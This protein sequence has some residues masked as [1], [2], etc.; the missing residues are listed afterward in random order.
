MKRVGSHLTLLFM[1]VTNSFLTFQDL[2]LVRYFLQ[3]STVFS[4]V[5]GLFWWLFF[6]RSNSLL[7]TDYNVF[8]PF[9]GLVRCVRYSRLF[10]ISYFMAW[11][12]FQMLLHLQETV[13]LPSIPPIVVF[14]F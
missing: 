13:S 11:I 10:S 9:M 8:V 1:A 7:F 5:T 14:G 3:D 2:R 6:R 12:L 4:L